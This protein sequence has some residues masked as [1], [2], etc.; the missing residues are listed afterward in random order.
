M[1]FVHWTEPIIIVTSPSVSVAAR[2]KAPFENII[3][4]ISILYSP[5]SRWKLFNPNIFEICYFL[6]H[7]NNKYVHMRLLKYH[8]RNQHTCLHLLTFGS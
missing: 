3:F 2:L 7:V 5:F 1:Q 4:E 6:L 8:I